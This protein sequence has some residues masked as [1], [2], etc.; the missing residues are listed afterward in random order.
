[1]LSELETLIAVEN[2]TAYETYNTVIES[3]K[4]YCM[5]YLSILDTDIYC[6][7]GGTTK[8]DRHRINLCHYCI[9]DIITMIN[10]NGK[11]LNNNYIKIAMLHAYKYLTSL[12]Q[13]SEDVSPC[14]FCLTC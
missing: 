5:E 1:M 7:N 11:L 14:L 2:A 13:I 6:E 9:Q 4:H 10:V 3:L 8:L 12:R